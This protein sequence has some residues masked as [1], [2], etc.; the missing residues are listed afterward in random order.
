M[1]ID[2]DM[3]KSGFVTIIGNPNAGKSTLMNALLGE[4]LSITSPKAQTTRE[5]VLGILNG[6]DYQIVFSDTPGILNPHYKLQ[7]S[8]LKSIENSVDEADV[9]ILITDVGEDFKN[10][11]IIERVQKTGTPIILLI[12]KIDTVTQ[13]E[14]M[15]KISYWQEKL[16]LKVRP[17]I[18]RTS[19]PTGTS[20][21]LQRKPFVS[22][23]FCNTSRKFPIRCRWKWKITR[24]CPSWT[25]SGR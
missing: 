10:P 1:K 11:S 12:N 13:E 21:S 25:G 23:S 6:A 19:F 3:H 20:V 9:F 24:K 15:Q 5:K 17:I 8:M 18:P 2:K 14:A 4:E 22:I 7:E 16:P